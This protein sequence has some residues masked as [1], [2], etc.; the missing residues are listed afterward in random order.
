[1]LKDIQVPTHALLQS[2]HRLENPKNGYLQDLQQLLPQSESVGATRLFLKD[3][4]SRLLKLERLASAGIQE[5][6]LVE[7]KLPKPKY[8]LH[9]VE[10]LSKVYLTYKAPTTVGLNK[11][12]PENSPYMQ[13]IRQSAEPI[14]GKKHGLMDQMKEFRDSLRSSAVAERPVENQR[15]QPPTT[16]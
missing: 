10:R 8:L 3:L 5:L 9:V 11:R 4:E 7:Q 15:K 14:I 16:N 2:I 6:E 12:Y 13:F 1:M